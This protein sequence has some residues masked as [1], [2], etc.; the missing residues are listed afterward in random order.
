M[1]SWWHHTWRLQ[2]SFT[3]SVACCFL[4]HLK[5]EKAKPKRHIQDMRKLQ[6][7]GLNAWWQDG[8]PHWSVAISS[9]CDLTQQMQ[10]LKCK[11]KE[12][13][14]KET[15]SALCI[16]WLACSAWLQDESM[17]LLLPI[18]WQTQ[19]LSEK[20]KERILP[21]T[22]K[23]MSLL[24]GLVLQSCCA[25][26]QTTWLHVALPNDLHLCR[27]GNPEQRIQL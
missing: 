10:E 4:Q 12:G 22:S 23:D 13:H 24:S 3:V 26:F 9:S 18:P 14:H 15:S 7:I 8:N 5:W 11:A 6:V 1:S 16:R 19:V 27:R 20:S 25:S 17:K 21:C 2:P